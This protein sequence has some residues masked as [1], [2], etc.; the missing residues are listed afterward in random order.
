MNVFLS[1]SGRASQDVAKTLR[2]WLPYMLHPV[3]PFMSTIDIGAGARW[4]DD[5]SRE[6]KDAQYGIV[7]VT[8]FNI[9]KPWMNFEAGALAHLPHLTPFLFRLDRMAL[10]HSP[11][12]EFQLTEFGANGER[13]KSEFCKLIESLNRGLGEDDRL[14]PEVLAANF[15]H[16]WSQL[17]RELDE[18]PDTSVG[19]TRTA[20]TWLRTFDDLAIHDLKPD[21]N[22]VWFVTGD[23]YKYALRAGVRERIEANL[24]T[25]KY[26]YLIPEPDGSSERAAREQ[27]ENLRRLHEGRID[28][29][30]V[31]RDVFRT[32]ATSD[33][34]IVQSSQADS[35]SVRVFVRAPIAEAE[36]E[37]WF[38]AE[39]RS[40]IGFHHRFQQL[41]DCPANVREALA[42]ESAH[43]MS[44]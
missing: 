18:I 22:V 38:D 40:A 7:C 13:S 21:C 33:Y 12:A 9:H 14:S 10:G 19:E 5:L 6:L 30:C 1:W 43:V 24:D 35:E 23:V 4:S 29:R 28:Y 31:N 8:P 34:V 11:L 20:Y 3:K 42:D 2:K 15:D 41:W 25:I 16:W 39:E 26:R 44:A 36:T 27:L 37:Y 17:K 32:Q